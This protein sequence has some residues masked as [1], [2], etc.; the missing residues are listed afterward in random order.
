MK[1]TMK[2]GSHR[3]D[4]LHNIVVLS[5]QLSRRTVLGGAPLDKILHY[6]INRKTSAFKQD[7]TVQK[8][9]RQPSTQLLRL[10]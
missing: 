3:L 1:Q 7:Q 6:H 2:A 5:G 4:F 8:A 10:F 9:S